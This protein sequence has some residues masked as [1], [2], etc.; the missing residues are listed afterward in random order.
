MTTAAGRVNGRHAPDAGAGRVV[1]R[2]VTADGDVTVPARGAVTFTPAPPVLLAAGAAPPQTMLPQPVTAVLDDDGALDVTLIATDD[3]GLNPTGWTYRVRARL[4]DG[5]LDGWQ[6]Y[7]I[8]VPAGSVTDLTLVT[9]VPPSTGEPVIVGPQGPAG[10][11]GPAGERGPAGTPGAPGAPGAPGGQGPAGDPGPQGPPGLAGDPG[12]PGTPGAAGP[13]GP[14]GVQGP[15]GPQGIPGPADPASEIRPQDC[16][17][18]AWTGNPQRYQGYTAYPAATYA[19]FLLLFPFM[20]GQGGPVTTISYAVN[21]AGAGLAD[22]YLGIYSEA[23]WLQGKCPDDQSANMTAVAARTATLEAPVTLAPGTL[24]RLGL[25]IG[26]ATT[27]PGLTGYTQ[28]SAAFTN[29]G[30]PSNKYLA[31][32]SGGGYTALPSTHGLMTAIPGGIIAVM[33]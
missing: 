22:A 33:S 24:Y 6:P 30:L 17:V 21:A 7:S 19:G 3:A 16:G 4:D 11:P 26:A 14:A 8:A 10:D 27:F 1:G 2:F 28:G 32:R 13:Q 12:T 18:V 23:G 20:S 5:R 9:P 25:V 29:L 31:C 15:Q